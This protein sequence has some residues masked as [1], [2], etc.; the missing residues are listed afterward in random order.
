MKKRTHLLFVFTV[1]AS[2]VSAQSRLELSLEDAVL[3]ALTNNYG[4]QILEITKQSSSEDV[5]QAAR[6]LFP[7]L[8]ASL[9]QG[10][11]NQSNSGNYSINASATLWNGGQSLNAIRRS[12]VA[13]SQSDSQIVQAQNTLIINVIQAFLTVLMNEDLYN[14]QSKVLEISEEQMKQGEIKYRSGQILESDYL[15]L[16]SQYANDNYSMTN[17]KI[18]RDNA[19]LELKTLLSIDPLDDVDIIAP[20]DDF[21]LETLGMPSLQELIDQTLA[22]LPDLKI[23]S[24][25]IELAQIDYRIAKGGYSPAIS[26]NGSIGTSYNSKSNANWG[27]QFTDNNVNQLSLSVSI[28]LWDK[29]K[30]RSNVK[31][32]NYRLEQAKIQE[33]QTL[34]DTRSSLEKEYQNVVSL[35]ERYYAAEISNNAYEETFRVF[36]IQFEQGSVSTTELLQQQNNYLSALNNYIQS[37]YSFLLNRKV[38]DVYMGMEIKI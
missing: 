5:S 6:D 17:S 14:Y 35:R 3:T 8:S 23:A 37:K 33:Q 21:S 19:I 28:P 2:M 18:N 7:N 22:W 12:K 16:K 34:L 32:A 10:V 9:S 38:L 4:Q 25:N 24:Q 27:S 36:S 26:L 20:P 31:Q 29:G 30:T 11:S 15:L 1:V 13:L